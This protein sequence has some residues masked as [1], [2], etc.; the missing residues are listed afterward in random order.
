MPQTT[1]ESLFLGKQ[2]LDIVVQFAKLA[3]AFAQNHV[4]VPSYFHQALNLCDSYIYL[5]SLRLSMWKNF[6]DIG[7]LDP[8]RWAFLGW[9]NPEESRAGIL[10]PPHSF[11]KK[12]GQPALPNRCDDIAIMTVRWLLLSWPLGRLILPCSNVEL[13]VPIWRGYWI[14]RQ[15]TVGWP[16]M[17][18]WT[19]HRT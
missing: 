13:G 18:I 3:E 4:K 17:L 10:P 9:R 5:T 15:C 2:S 14:K 1:L 11:V 8:F 7:A 6:R 16:I 12:A 19:R